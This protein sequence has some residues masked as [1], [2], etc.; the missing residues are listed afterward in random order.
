MRDPCS[1][2]HDA[3]KENQRLHTLWKHAEADFTQVL[4]SY[5]QYGQAPATH[6][7]QMTILNR[8]STTYSN[9]RHINLKGTDSNSVTTCNKQLNSRG[10]PLEDLNQSDSL[11]TRK[12]DLTNLWGYALTSLTRSLFLTP[13]LCGHSAGITHSHCNTMTSVLQPWD[14]TNEMKMPI[15]RCRGSWQSGVHIHEVLTHKGASPRRALSFYHK[16]CCSCSGTHDFTY[17]GFAESRGKK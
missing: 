9:C 10:F 3:G 11:C 15:K 2:H 8:S 5:Y 4:F 6:H 12:A 13:P 7:Q 17:Y 16:T 14:I 1:A